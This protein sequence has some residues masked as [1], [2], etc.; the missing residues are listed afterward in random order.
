M[1]KR[2][3]FKDVFLEDDINT[4]ESLIYTDK[5]R[6]KPFTGVVVDYFQGVLL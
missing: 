3:I 5:E 2:Q 1:Q 4:G 6:T